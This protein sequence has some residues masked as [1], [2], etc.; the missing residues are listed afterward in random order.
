MIKRINSALPDDVIFFAYAKV[1]D[2][3]NAR[4]TAIYREYHYYFFSEKCDIEKMKINAKKFEGVHDFKNFCKMK[5]QYEKNGTTREVI[6]CEVV[7]CEN[8]MGEFLPMHVFICRGKGFL[9]H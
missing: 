8:K 3:F 2:D 1:R 4:F 9:W 6:N 5:P 7:S